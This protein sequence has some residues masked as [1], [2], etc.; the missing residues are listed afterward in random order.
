MDVGI[1]WILELRNDV[2]NVPDDW[3]SSVQVPV[4]KRKGDPMFI[5]GNKPL[6]HTMKVVEREMLNEK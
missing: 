3:K 2:R 1:Q 5:A 6:E 4:Y